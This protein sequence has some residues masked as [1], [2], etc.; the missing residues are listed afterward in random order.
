[1]AIRP[2]PL[3]L[4]IMAFCCLGGCQSRPQTFI[5]QPATWNSVTIR[6][7]LAKD[8]AW[9]KVADLLAKNYD[10]E[11]MNKDTGYIRTAY[12]LTM[13]R[14]SNGQMESCYRKRV[15]AKIQSDADIIEIKTEAG[16]WDATCWVEG[17]DSGDL[18]TL[19]TDIAAV[20]GDA[21]K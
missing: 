1:M 11:V 13:D 6:K 4:F 5:E 7:G 21:T 18:S 17:Y 8:A 12:K 20:I 3:F 14:Y 10:L 9:Q 16:W 15:T 19:K 2:L